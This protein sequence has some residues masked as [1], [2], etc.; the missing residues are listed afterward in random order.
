MSTPQGG[1]RRV[2]VA[3][4]VT[5]N[6][7]TGDHARAEFV[8]EGA[9]SGGAAETPEVRQLR[10]AVADLR[11]CLRALAPDELPP[12]AAE[13]AA[14]ALD[15]LDDALPADEEPGPGRVRRAVFMVSGALASAAALADGVRALRDAAAPWF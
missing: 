12:A 3:G 13:E 11:E 7:Q 15:E 6:I 2:H 9:A 14:G 1:D 5:G 4:Q 10:R 8:Q